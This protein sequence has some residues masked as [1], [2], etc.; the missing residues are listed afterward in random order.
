V[1]KLLPIVDYVQATCTYKLCVTPR[2][3]RVLLV[4]QTARITH[5][6]LLQFYTQ[7]PTIVVTSGTH[8]FSSGYFPCHHFASTSQLRRLRSA[9]L[10]IDDI[11]ELLERQEYQYGSRLETCEGGKP[12]FEH[13]HRAFVF[14]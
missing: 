11:L 6:P 12:A 1:S 3:S 4:Q 5:T 10:P 2:A 7:K 9:P 8:N 14:E 13:E